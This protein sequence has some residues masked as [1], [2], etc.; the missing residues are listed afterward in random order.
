MNA[1]LKLTTPLLLLLLPVILYT[2]QSNKTS[3]S[4]KSNSLIDSLIQIQRI[5]EKTITVSFGAD[6]I[7]A[8][9]TEQGIVVID[10][11][12]STG[13]T[14]MFR[15][16]I[17]NEFQGSPFTYVINTHAHH[18]H[19]RG[20]SVFPEAEIVGH[21]NGIE[22]IENQWNDPEKMQEFLKSIA[23]EYKTKLQNSVPNSEEWYENFQQLIRYQFAYDDA[24]GMIPILKPTIIFFE[25]HVIHM[26]NITLEMQYFGKCHSN[27]DILIFVPELRL[28]FTGDLMFQYGRPSIHDKTM[29]EKEIWLKSLAWIEKRMHYIDTVI[30]GHG[31]LLSVDDLTAFVGIINDTIEQRKNESTL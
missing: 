9:K 2:C 17:E 5:N 22:S 31:Q 18:D 25:A 29:A 11:G 6:A 3:L 12:I 10:A 27:S 7:S 16:K 1:S 19:Y 23:G 24:I 15:K 8:I 21:E 26:G 14:S 4:D 28:L 13:L 20:N 30:G